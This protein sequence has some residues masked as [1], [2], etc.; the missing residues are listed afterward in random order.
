MI[1]ISFFKQF[2]LTV[3]INSLEQMSHYISLNN[4]DTIKIVFKM[5]TLQINLVLLLPLSLKNRLHSKILKKDTLQTNDIWTNKQSFEKTSI[6][7][8]TIVRWKQLE[9][10]YCKTKSLFQIFINW[11]IVT[12]FS[13]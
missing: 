11:F 3:F 1:A 6:V 5:I 12:N 4:F 8:K 10:L 9:H 2:L 7:R 13:L